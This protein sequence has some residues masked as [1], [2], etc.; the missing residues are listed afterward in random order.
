MKQLVCLVFLFLT[1]ILKAQWVCMQFSIKDQD[2]RPVESASITV[3]TA[4]K[5][6]LPYA[7]KKFKTMIIRT[8]KKGLASERFMCWDGHVIVSVEASGYYG[9]TLRDLSFKT[10]Y[11]MR[12]RETVFLEKEKKV[13]ICLQARKN[14]VPL[15]SYRG[16]NR[17]WSF[18][19][20]ESVAGYDLKIGDWVHP[21]GRGEVADFFIR[22]EMIPTNGT[23]RCVASLT[24]A[25]G[26]GAYV[27][28]TACQKSTPL[29]YEAETNKLLQTEFC[30]VQIWDASG[31]TML[32]GDKLLADKEVLVIRSRAKID[33]TGNVI[34]A[35][36][37][38]V[39][40]PFSIAGIFE[41]RQSFFNPRINDA[42]LEL[43]VG[44]NLSGER[45]GEFCP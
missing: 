3:E 27:T 20:K 38:K 25:Q 15:Y 8:D 7:S 9:K 37:S 21:R 1:M 6:T 32:S 18:G 29:I 45:S 40:G 26:C 24:F 16:L 11:D 42:N 22:H 19:K 13:D 30:V 5:R 33:E 35:N 39:Y 41:F 44:R 4:E 10:N 36:Y 34:E 17:V 31:R 43:D 28:G 2:G 12:A 23:Y 14:P